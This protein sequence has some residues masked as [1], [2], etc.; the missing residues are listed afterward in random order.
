MN[1]KN[2]VYI[3]YGSN[4]NLEQMK[5]RCPD[6]KVIG[7]AMLEDY[8]LEFR[9][10]AT[11]VPKKGCAVPVLLWEI[12]PQDEKALDKY[13]GFPYLYRKEE[14]EIDLNG[15]KVTGMAYV[16]NGGQVSAPGLGYQRVIAQGYDENHLNPEFLNQAVY[17]ARMKDYDSNVQESEEMQENSNIS[18]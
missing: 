14:Y 13:E 6:S 3:A 2:K 8:E 10:V 12:S 1:I 5:H 15:Q 11:I 7:T 9:G 18:M 16:M 17:N 4:L